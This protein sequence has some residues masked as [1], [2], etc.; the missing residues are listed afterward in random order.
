MQRGFNKNDEVFFGVLL[1]AIAWNQHQEELHAFHYMLCFGLGLVGSAKIFGAYYQDWL[2]NGHRPVTGIPPNWAICWAVLIVF[3]VIFG[4]PHLRY[5][6]G[7]RNCEYY[8]WE[9]VQLKPIKDCKLIEFF[10]IQ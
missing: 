6:I 7:F 3:A 1:L 8:G 5:D 2:L 4:T 10:P 9:G